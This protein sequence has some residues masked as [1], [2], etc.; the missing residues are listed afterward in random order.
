MFRTFCKILVFNKKKNSLFEKISVMELHISMKIRILIVF[1]VLVK[2]KNFYSGKSW[3][4]FDSFRIF[5]AILKKIA[6]KAM[7]FEKSYKKAKIAK[8]AKHS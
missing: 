1:S 8:K 3:T 7:K 4:I 6:K 2:D 5:L